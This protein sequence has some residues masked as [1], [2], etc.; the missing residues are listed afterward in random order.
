MGNH[1]TLS[2][3]SGPPSEWMDGLDQSALATEGNRCFG[4]LFSLSKVRSSF[5]GW[6]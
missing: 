5:V 4:R 2:M 1:F 3:L 6:Y